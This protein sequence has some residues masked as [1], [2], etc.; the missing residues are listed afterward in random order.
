MCVST[1]IVGS[2]NA[3]FNTTFAVFLPTPGNASNAT[4]SRGTLESCASIKIW[5]VLIIFLAFVLNNPIVLM[6]ALRPFS[7]NA[8]I[9]LGVFATLYNFCVALFTLTSV[10]WAERITATSN[11]K[12]DAYCSS[13]VGAGLSR[14]SLRKNNF[15]CFRSKISYRADLLRPRWPTTG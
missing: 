5:Q 2:P 12:A 15:R 4:R 6:Y 13:V 10:A 8:I 7:P 9:E 14:L 1:A 3:V 11:S